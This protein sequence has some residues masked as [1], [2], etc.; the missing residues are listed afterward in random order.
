M[1]R[2]SRQQYRKRRTLMDY[3]LGID[4]GGTNYRVEAHNP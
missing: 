1:T 4:S 3:V 2:V